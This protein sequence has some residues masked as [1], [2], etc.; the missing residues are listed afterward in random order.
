MMTAA[1]GTIRDGL[2]VS[3]SRINEARHPWI[4]RAIS[5]RL[6]EQERLRQS[7]WV[8]SHATRDKRRVY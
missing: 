3:P 2:Y 6:R 4:S 5:D 7:C 1:S 8:R